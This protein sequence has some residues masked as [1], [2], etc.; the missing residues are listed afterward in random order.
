MSVGTVRAALVAAAPVTALVPE[1]R[2]EPLRRTQSFAV[3]AITIQVTSRIPYNHLR[4]GGAL[5]RY[6]DQVDYWATNYTAARAIADAGLA[7]LE[8][9]GHLME[10]EIDSGHEPETDPELFRITQIWSVIT[11]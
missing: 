6:L 8:A 11:A 2:I 1:A 9:A 5:Y 7:A 3:P 4:A 10:S